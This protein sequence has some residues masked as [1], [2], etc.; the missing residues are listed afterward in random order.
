[1]A[2]E[3]AGTYWENTN[4]FLDGF[5]DTFAHAGEVFASDI[6]NATMNNNATASLQQNLDDRE[7]RGVFNSALD[8]ASDMYGFDKN[9]VNTKDV[10]ATVDNVLMNI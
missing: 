1:M 7:K 8:D 2:E 4:S 9:M 5:A 3:Q 6:Q 10:S